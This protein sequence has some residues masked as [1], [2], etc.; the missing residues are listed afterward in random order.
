MK[1]EGGMSLVTRKSGLLSP[2]LLLLTM[3]TMAEAGLA[4]TT[5]WRGQERQSG[6]GKSWF[7]EHDN[8]EDI[9]GHVGN[10]SVDE[11][12]RKM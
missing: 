1:R 8:D 12:Y 7:Y 11:R 6:E 3:A 9:E 10:G 5:G 2:P 4:I